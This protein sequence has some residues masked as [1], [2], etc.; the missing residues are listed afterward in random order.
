[1]KKL[2]KKIEVKPLLIGI[3]LVLFQS[4]LFFALRPIQGT[5]HLIGDF[6]DAKIPF[7]KYFIIP[8]YIWF[9]MIFAMPYYY[10]KKD[11]NLLS[12]YI[13]SYV[14]CALVATVIFTVYPS[15]VARPDYLPNNSL[16]NLMVNL[17]YWIDNPPINCF[18]SMHCAVSMLFILTINNSKETKLSTKLLIIFVSLLIMASTLYTKQ[19]V[20][21]DLISGDIFMT[22]IYTTFSKNIKLNNYIKKLLKL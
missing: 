22:F 20:F 4:I 7:V 12:K 9:I 18:P 16:I 10:Y 15:I 17:I 6:I 1:M 11:K 3:G 13:I 14:V 19:H 21:K 2:I 5:P 8:Y